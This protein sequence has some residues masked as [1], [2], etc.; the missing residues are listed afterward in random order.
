MNNVKENK[1]SFIASLIL[2]FVLASCNAKSTATIPLIGEPLSASSPSATAFAT[3]FIATNTQQ[4]TLDPVEERCANT[5]PVEQLSPDVNGV[6]LSYSL[7]PYKVYLSDTLNN[8]KNEMRFEAGLTPYGIIISPDQKLAALSM[9]N[10]DPPSQPTKLRIINSSGKTKKEI[11]WKSEWGRIAAWL[12]NHRVL[13]A[14]S[15][16]LE[17][18]IYNPKSILLLDINTGEDVEIQA[19]YPDVNQIE[20]V[21]LEL[22]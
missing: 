5:M 21:Q 15:A 22:D 12:D 2:L 13:I 17:Q 7:D 11:M 20:Y 8:N 9:S 4:N 1:L 19:A 6:L 10:A 14:K 18:S 3:Q 16:D